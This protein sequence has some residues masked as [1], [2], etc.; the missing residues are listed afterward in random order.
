MKMRMV[1]YLCNNSNHFFLYQ[2]IVIIN[3]IVIIY[4]HGELPYLFGADLNIQVFCAKYKANT[5]SDQNNKQ[6][7]AL[8]DF[9]QRKTLGS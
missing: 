2:L 6:N 1:A 9:E 8:Q 3:I 7:D 4:S 5:G